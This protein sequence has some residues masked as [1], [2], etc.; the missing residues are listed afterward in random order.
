MTTRR[1]SLRLVDHER[2]LLVK[3]YLRWRIPVDQFEKRPRELAAFTGE[4]S[5]LSGRSDLATD[6]LHYMRTRRKRGL[7]VR[8]DGDHEAGP[9]CLDLSAEETEIL[10][11]IYT[12]VTALRSGSDEI[13][14]D[15][16]VQS[17]IAKE[18][19]AETG[20]VVPVHELVAKLTALRKRGLLPPKD[21]HADGGVEGFTDMDKVA[22]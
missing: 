7:W 3:L 13:G 19:A 17:L 14:Y 10:V 1:K 2:E 15:A 11:A 9:P 18:F 16:E 12:E 4:W 20:R 21:P 5:T 22:E 6:V 8:F